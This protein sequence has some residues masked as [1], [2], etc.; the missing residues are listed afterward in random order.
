[1]RPRGAA[2]G[3]PAAQFVTMQGYPALA[4]EQVVVAA[5]PAGFVL[6]PGGEHGGQLIAQPARHG[7]VTVAGLGFGRAADQ[8]VTGIGVAVNGHQRLGHPDHP[9][10]PS[11][12]VSLGST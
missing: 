6:G 1:M 11:F 5:Y 8:T 10:N 9:L 7:D 12:A 2:P 3:Y 4:D